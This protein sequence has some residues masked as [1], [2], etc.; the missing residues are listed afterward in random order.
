MIHIYIYIYI[1]YPISYPSLT[2]FSNEQKVYPIASSVQAVS[3]SLQV[4]RYQPRC[5]AVSG[6]LDSEEIAA[7]DSLQK[8]LKIHEVLSVKIYVCI[9]I[10]ICIDINIYIYIY[11]FIYV[12]SFIYNHFIL[13]YIYIY[14]ILGICISR[15]NQYIVNIRFHPS[16]S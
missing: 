12:L 3:R 5:G 1:I 9:C 14:I 6:R 7:V 4:S 10:C 15:I 11:T 2:S 8:M 16:H 13:L